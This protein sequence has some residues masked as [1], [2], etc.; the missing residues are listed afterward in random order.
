MANDILNT[1][2]GT[3]GN[4]IQGRV[5]FHHPRGLVSGRSGETYDPADVE[6]TDITVL[7]TKYDTR[8]DDPRYYSGDAVT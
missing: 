5:R 4:Q 8:W 7:T 6:T 1:A 3:S 2:G